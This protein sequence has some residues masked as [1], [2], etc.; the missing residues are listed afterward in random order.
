[1]FTH[2]TF[3]PSWKTVADPRLF[4]KAIWA[5]AERLGARFEQ[6]HFNHAE[7]LAG[8]ENEA[9]VRLSFADG[10]SHRTRRLLISAGA[11]SHF[12]ATRLGDRI[13]LE[14]ER[15]YNTTLPR[16]A[17][18]LHRQLTFVGHGFVVSPLETG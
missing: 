10:A 16:G 8:G 12:H 5:H 2:G 7:T 4:G 9:T 6:K 11:W 3:M 17:F 15:G 13:P 1:R 18:D 14:T